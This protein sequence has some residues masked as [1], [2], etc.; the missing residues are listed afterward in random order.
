MVRIV[1]FLAL[2]SIY[3]MCNMQ[4]FPGGAPGFRYTGG[5]TEY[6]QE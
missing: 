5:N 3:A 1:S 4:C 2:T 6:V